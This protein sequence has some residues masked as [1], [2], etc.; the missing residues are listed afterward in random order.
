MEFREQLAQDMGIFFNPEEFADLHTINGVEVA[1]VI[2]NDALADLYISKD[3]NTDNLFA[4]SMLV[5]IPEAALEFEPVPGQHVDFDG[6]M[7]IISDVKLDG[8]IYAVVLGVN[9][10]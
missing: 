3:T 4:D 8:G 1:A 10:H 7:Y 6:H 2:D 5:Y 9:G